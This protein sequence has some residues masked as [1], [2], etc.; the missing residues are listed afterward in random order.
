M[1]IHTMKK[2]NKIVDVLKM[3]RHKKISVDDVTVILLADHGSVPI[4]FTQ[5]TINIVFA[6]ITVPD[7]TKNIQQYVH[8]EYIRRLKQIL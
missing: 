1:K 8:N 4:W 3:M 7:N 5:D 2:A 6:K